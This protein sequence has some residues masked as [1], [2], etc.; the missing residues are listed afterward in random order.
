[1]YADIG[2]LECLYDA[3][4]SYRADNDAHAVLV[5]NIVFGKASSLC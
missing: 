3:N 2:A 5:R 1:M 4:T